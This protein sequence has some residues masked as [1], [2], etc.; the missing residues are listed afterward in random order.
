MVNPLAALVRTQQAVTVSQSL[1][2]ERH[3]QTCVC[4]ACRNNLKKD[5]RVRNRVN[6]FRFKKGGFGALLPVC[7]RAARRQAY[8]PRVSTACSS[9]QHG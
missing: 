1:V 7:A 2:T 8:A 9:G 4:M 5:K 3:V 6:A